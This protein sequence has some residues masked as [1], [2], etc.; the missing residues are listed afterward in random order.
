MPHAI[1][2]GMDLLLDARQ[3]CSLSMAPRRAILHAAL[4]G[5]VHPDVPASHLQQAQM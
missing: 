2:A 4:Y 1:T 3:N 5:P